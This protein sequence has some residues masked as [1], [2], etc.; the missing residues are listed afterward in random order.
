MHQ[1]DIQFKKKKDLKEPTSFF[2]R[3]FEAPDHSVNITNGENRLES[4]RWSRLG[5]AT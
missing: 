3:H 1:L 5:R 2:D 4:F